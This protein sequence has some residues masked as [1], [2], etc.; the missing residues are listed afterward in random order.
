MA[1]PFFA[2]KTFF[3]VKSS[4]PYPISQQALMRQRCNWCPPT[5]LSS[6]IFPFK[7]EL[8]VS[9]R[10]HDN[11]F[12]NSFISLLKALLSQASMEILWSCN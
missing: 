11:A 6:P 1:K 5:V 7:F 8:L 10:L 9:V 12:C 4:H 2:D 3:V